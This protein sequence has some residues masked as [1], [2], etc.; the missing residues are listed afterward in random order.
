MNGFVYSKSDLQTDN[1]DLLTNKCIKGFTSLND[2][3]ID[4]VNL[5]DLYKVFN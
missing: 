5:I 3:N 1:T 2:L 4:Q